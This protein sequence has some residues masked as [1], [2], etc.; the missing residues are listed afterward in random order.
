MRA[1]RIRS[2]IMG[3]PRKQVGP[4]K[5]LEIATTSVSDALGILEALFDDNAGA[6]TKDQHDKVFGFIQRRVAAA[7]ATTRV[8]VDTATI[9]RQPFS[10]DMDLPDA[11]VPMPNVHPNIPPTPHVAGHTMHFPKE[12]LAGAPL[13]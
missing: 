3:R 12:A 11:V 9:S 2:E 5:Q 7:Y 4:D 1:R 8:T 6:Y 10:L 13:R